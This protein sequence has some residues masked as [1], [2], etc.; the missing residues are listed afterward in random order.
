MMALVED[1]EEREE[2]SRNFTNLLIVCTV[3]L[4]AVNIYQFNLLNDKRGLEYSYLV[5]S[6][7][8][9][10]LE[11][12]YDELTGSYL[13]LRAD[14]SN[15]NDEYS[16]LVKRHYALQREYDE[17]FNLRKEQTLAKDEVIVLG[18]GGN[19]TLVYNLDAAGYVEVDFRASGEV[20]QWVGSSLVDGVYYSR[21]PPFPETS[22]A[23]IFRVPAASQLYIYLI[24][25]DQGK[26][27]EVS[28]SISYVY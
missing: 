12:Y 5:L 14:Y 25:P 13:S 18:P 27:V 28:L 16:D 6:N 26:E 23:G 19:H 1:Y 4:L 21:Y 3:L 17:F 8:S 20:F 11:S 10:L 7:R 15:L 22:K 2:R 9:S 24:N